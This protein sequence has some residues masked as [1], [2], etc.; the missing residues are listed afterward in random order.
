M[1]PS[2]A[3]LVSARR[4]LVVGIGGLG[5]AAATALGRAGI[6]TIGL[7]DFDA[8]EISNLPR[9]VLYDES[10][11]GTAKPDAAARRLSALAPGTSFELHRFRFGESNLEETIAFARRYEF[12]ID[13]TD[14]P[15]SKYRLNDIAVAARRPLAHAG[16]TGFRGQLLGIAPGKT[17]CLRCVFPDHSDAD[18]GPACSEA[19]VLGPLVGVFGM[20]QAA[21]ALAYFA[22]RAGEFGDRL[23]VADHGRWRTVRTSRDRNCRTCG[24]T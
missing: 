16:V 8:V 13:G 1:L 11:I 23:V 20:L 10:D 3:S 4:V 21:A 18:E 6:G 2:E 14:T 7:C 15:A 12:L 22:N 17:A 24:T 9:Q 19:G 5:T